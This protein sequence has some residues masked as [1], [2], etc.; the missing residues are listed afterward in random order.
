[1]NK[2]GF[3]I[4]NT[5]VPF[6][7]D[8]LRQVKPPVILIHAGDRGL[9]RDIRRELSP[10]SFVV[11]RIFVDLREQVAWLDDQDPEARGR[12]FADRIINFDFGLA[13]ER[14]AN[15]RL[16]IDAWMSL[17]ETLPGPASASGTD[18]TF[19][20]RAAALDRFQVAFW[21]RLRSAGLEAVAFNFAAGNFTQPEHYLDW[22]P[23]TLE[24]HKYLGFHEYGWPKLMEDPAKGWFS[25]ALHYRRVMQGIRARY[26][27]RH[28]AIITEAGLA[29]M[30]KFPQSEAGD[31]G[32]LYPGD[33]ISEEDYWQ[34]LSWY[35]SEMVKDDFVLGACL[36][37]VGHSGRW[38]TF[39]HLGVDNQQRPILLM[40]RIASLNVAPP[41]PPP[42]PAPPTPPPPPPP[43]PEV[44]LVALQRR[45]ADL[46]G[47]LEAALASTTALLN[48]MSRLRQSLDVMAPTAAQTANL[49]QEVDQLLARLDRMEAEVNR[50]EATG[51]A[52]RDAIALARQRLAALRGQLNSLKPTAQQAAAFSASLGQA[53]RT[54]D[55]LNQSTPQNQ[56]LQRQLETLVAE[57]RRLA[58]QVG[59]P[60]AQPNSPVVRVVGPAA[61]DGRGPGP[62]STARF[63]TRPVEGIRHI[64]VHHTLTRNDVTPERLIEMQTRRG[65]PG[66]RFHYLVA[67]DGQVTQLQPL[68]ALLP[69]TNSAAVNET[70]VAVALAGNFSQAIPNDAQLDGAAR[71]VAWLL[72][73]LKLGPEAVIGRSEVDAGVVSPGAQWLQ[74]AVFKEM[75]LDRVAALLPVSS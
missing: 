51:R 56:A 2:L 47:R 45:T 60:P 36:F 21:E 23:R 71:L 31:V 40:N 74:G 34:S 8:A 30:Y 38:E 26:G 63:P 28:V 54:F 58:E 55:T 68:E 49:P 9:L 46:V 25:S 41:P 20:R 27:N 35:N 7:R 14:G 53:R 69:Q 24:T 65:Q 29:R 70:G 75:L 62:L 15:G 5:T 12:A 39:R 17:N 48:Q 11:G 57:G 61:E 19:R 16:L 10:D 33:T 43:A 59:P 22:F 66:V 73:S 32:W 6:L 42:P 37:Q 67:H 72:Y 64:V 4:E 50:I 52:N 13:S 1:M 44:D 18:A 3:Y